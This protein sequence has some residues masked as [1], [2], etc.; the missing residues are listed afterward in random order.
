MR[1]YASLLALLSAASL[2]FAAG[3]S[4]I[5]TGVIGLLLLSVFIIIIFRR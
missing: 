2:N 3:E 4:E 1:K 5:V